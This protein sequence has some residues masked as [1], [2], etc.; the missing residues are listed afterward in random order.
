V[1]NATVKRWATQV[2]H[3]ICHDVVIVKDVGIDGMSSLGS[4][5]PKI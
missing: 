3:G 2:E 1:Y 5:I 4:P